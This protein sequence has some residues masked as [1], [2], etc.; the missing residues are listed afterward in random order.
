MWCKQ[1][2]QD[3]PAR[4]SGDKQ[5]I[6]CPR[7]GREIRAISQEEAGN[8]MPSAQVAAASDTPPALG[9]ESP[10]YDS[11]EIDEQLRHIQ[12]TLQNG[13][14]KA[15]SDAGRQRETVRFDSAQAALSGNHVS[16]SKRPDPSQKTAAR[17]RNS[18][19]GVLLWIALAIG[20]A[21]CACG[22]VLLAWSLVA[23]RHELWTV[24]L[25]TMLI[26]QIALLAGLALQFDRLWRDNHAASVKLDDMD[27]NLYELRTTAAV[28]GTQPNPAMTAFYSRLA[29]GANPQTLPTDPNGRS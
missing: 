29:V 11:W 7:C 28:L 8:S 25:P 14:G 1:C 20:T 16:T 18:G 17:R 15:V 3:V 21:G 23:G 2:R 10:N 4:P 13:K 19:S 9:G 12:R 27:R 22:G 6:C 5:A 24:G 26:G